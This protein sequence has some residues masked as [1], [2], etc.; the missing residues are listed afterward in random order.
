MPVTLRAR[1]GGARIEAPGLADADAPAGAFATA[2]NLATGAR[3]R[4]RV[5]PDG[6]IE[7]FP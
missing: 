5:A 6:A 2:R 4:G 3:V 7:I 1:V